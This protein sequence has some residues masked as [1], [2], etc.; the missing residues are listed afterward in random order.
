MTIH[1][2]W[3]TA[4]TVIIWSEDIAQV[5]RSTLRVLLVSCSEALC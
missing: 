5:H 3:L 4:G 1:D 2:G